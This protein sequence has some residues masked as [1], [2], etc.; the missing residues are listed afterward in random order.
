MVQFQIAPRS[1]FHFSISVGPFWCSQSPLQGFLS[2]APVCSEVVAFVYLASVC[3]SLQCLIFALTQ[4]GGGDLFFRL[5][6]PL[7]FGEGGELLSPSVLLRLPAALYG[8]CPALCA[9][10]ALGCSTKV[11]TRLHLRS[12][13]SPAQPAQAARSFMGALSP[14]AVCLLPSASPAPVP[15]SASRVS[16]PCV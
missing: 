1:S 5:L 12:V 2:V 6:V 3:W 11:W 14:G 10:P 15:A 8:V 13:P 9:V 7:R 16:A 4:A